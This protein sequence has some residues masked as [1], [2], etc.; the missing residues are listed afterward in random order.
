MRYLYILLF[1]IFGGCLSA[2]TLN[3]QR[4]MKES[5]I[6][7]TKEF[8]LFTLHGFV[9]IDG[10]TMLNDTCKGAILYEANLDNI[11]LIDTL[12]KIEYTHRICSVKG[13]PIIHLVKKEAP[14]VKSTPVLPLPLFQQP[15][16]QNL[17]LVPDTIIEE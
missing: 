10:H 14:V 8:V 12:N 2:Q 5:H 13:C 3:E 7:F 4:T 17:Q 11:V 15:T 9:E 6:D 16:L 1:L